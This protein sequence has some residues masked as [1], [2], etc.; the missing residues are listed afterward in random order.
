MHA[1]M[2]ALPYIPLNCTALHTFLILDSIHTW[3]RC[4]LH[5]PPWVHDG[6]GKEAPGLPAVA[7][8]PQTCID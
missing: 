1:R 5:D 7:T 3:K 8:A 4:Y 2:R 6:P